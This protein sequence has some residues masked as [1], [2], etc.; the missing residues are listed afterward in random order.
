M[1]ASLRRIFQ[2]D[3]FTEALKYPQKPRSLQK[4]LFQD[5]AKTLFLRGEAIAVD[6][7]AQ[8]LPDRDFDTLVRSGLMREDSGRVC[9]Y[10]KVQSYQGLVFLSDFPY[11]HKAPDFVLPI[12]PAGHYLAGLTIR[13]QVASVLDLG[14]GCGV[15]SLLAA[16]HCTRVTATDINPRAL[17]FTR[18]NSELNGVSNIEILQGSYFEPVEGR[19]FDLIV[20]N[21]P[22]VIAPEKWV[23]YRNT[24][25]P[26]DASVRRLIQEIPAHLSEGG[27]AHI[28]ANWIHPAEAPWWQPMRMAAEGNKADAW[29]IYNGS[30]D[31]QTYAEM[32][33]DSEIKNDARALDQTKKA[34][35]NWYSRNGI[36]RIALGAVTLRSRTS[37]SNWFCAALVDSSLES[38]AGEQLQ[39]L[40]AAQ[41]TLS[42]PRHPEDIFDKRWVPWRMEMTVDPGGQA[43]MARSSSGL[44]LQVKIQV[45]SAKVVEH[46]SVGIDLRNALDHTAQEQ[47]ILPE[48]A[49]AAVLEDIR[50]LIDL[51]MVI[52]A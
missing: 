28:L 1:A 25:R 45:L 16:R 48:S 20:A 5:T 52:P 12:G 23:I 50:R 31:V 40:F 21:L 44:R 13:R 32:W 29:L 2:Q 47:G 37:G 11:R 49:S 36:E 33:I 10:F 26:G 17:S 6:Q 42:A 19:R 24:D 46:L 7:A 30:K 14:C 22:Y 39:R 41:D 38:P 35:G 51:G 8:V 27:Y 15:Q 34:W 18:L 9:S 43:V 4:D 3:V